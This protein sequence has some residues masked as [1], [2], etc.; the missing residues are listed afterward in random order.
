MAID[1]S[2]I[3]RLAN[4][5]Y[6]NISKMKLSQIKP[7]IK[8]AAKTANKLRR[9][10]REKFKNSGIP[11]SKVYGKG[12]PYLKAFKTFDKNATPQNQLHQ[13]QHNLMLI[14]NFMRDKTKTFE[15]MKSVI[16]DFYDKVE[17]ELGGNVISREELTPRKW[18]TFWDIFNAIEERA[19]NENVFYDSDTARMMTYKV[20][21]RTD[22]GEFTRGG[23][24][25]RE[26]KI[27][28]IID[29]MKYYNLSEDIENNLMKEKIKERIR[30]ERNLKPKKKKSTD[31]IDITNDEGWL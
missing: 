13:A 31:S 23:Y 7:L 18:K 8:S 30:S 10:E 19:S 28:E 12:S 11:L 6:E 15:G 5:Q 26:D 14:R 20:L 29:E 9:E 25:N 27:L 17:E 22:K 3:E 24:R 4:L 16:E 21:F 2:E 1:E